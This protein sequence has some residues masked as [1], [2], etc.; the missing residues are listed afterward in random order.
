MTDVQ[1]AVISA[2]TRTDPHAGAEPGG[3]CRLPFWG[4]MQ[5]SGADAASFLHGQLSND[6]NR[7]DGRQAR[8][9]GYCNAQGRMLASL[10]VTRRD[11]DTIWLLCAADLLPATLKRL[12]MF[13]LRAKCKLSD[14]S[15]GLTVLGLAGEPALTHL[16]L[17]MGRAPD[18]PAWSCHEL[19][20]AR[21]IRLPDAP[22]RPGI[23]PVATLPRWLWIGPAE[24]AVALEAALPA[25]SPTTWDRLDVA[26]GVAPVQAAT[27]GLFVPQ[28]LNYELVGGVDFKK[29]CYPGQEI[30]ARSQYLG[31]L[32][33]R[34]FLLAGDTVARPG[35]EVYWSEDAQQPAGQ[36]AVAADAAPGTAPALALAELKIGAVG[37]GTLHLGSAQGPVLTVLPLPYAV[38]KPG[39]D[40]GAAA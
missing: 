36:I 9:A 20:D 39:D 3:A 25:L 19:G 35:Q 24:A 2:D 33:R 32:K 5:A 37:S 10:L 27:S 21:V 31:K 29:G 1:N 34:A 26:A 4:V 16:G 38:P 18:A 30:V 28:M 11:A 12:S 8:L 7:L 17:A 22:A 6:V 40:A 23:S 13:V 14:A 15:A